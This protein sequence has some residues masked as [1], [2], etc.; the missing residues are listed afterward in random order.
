MKHYNIPIFIPHE[1]CPNDCIF[2]NQRKITGL[3]S[4]VQP[5]SVTEL[6]RKYLDYLPPGEK[7]VEAAFFGGS[8][9]GLPLFLQEEFYRAASVYQ[10]E[11]DGIRLSTRPDYINPEVLSL[12]RRWGVTLIELG[13]QSSS[14]EVLKCNRRL[15]TF[16]DTCAAVTQIRKSGIKV[17]LQMMTG[18]YG[19][20]IRSDLKTAEDFIELAPDCVRIYPTVVLKETILDRL[21]R[22]G[23]Y[24]PQSLEQ[25]VESA[26]EIL[27]LFRKQNIPV[28]RLGLHAGEDI[29][30]PGVISAGPFHPAF[31]ELVESRIWRDRLERQWLAEQRPAI[32][33]VQVPSCEVSKAIG[34]RRCNARY[35][36]E[37][38]G[39]GLCISPVPSKIISQL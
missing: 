13:A 2:C 29:Q 38:Y 39:T 34:H 28:I 19:A 7:H 11:I 16:S 31:G 23:R 9:T 3:E 14:D 37:K 21:Y 22:Q 8:F 33:R 27:L 20:D 32:L 25:A 18:M 15:H 26:K 24:I 10:K 35:F 36:K 30:K 12:A 17:G 4:S 6:I 1:G 5:E